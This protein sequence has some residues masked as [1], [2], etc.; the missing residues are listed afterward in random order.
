VVVRGAVVAIHAAVA[1]VAADDADVLPSLMVAPPPDADVARPTPTEVRRL[2]NVLL[3][4]VILDNLA[5]DR[6][7]FG[8]PRPFAHTPANRFQ[9]RE[10]FVR[11]R[12]QQ[13]L[14]ERGGHEV[15]QNLTPGR[16]EQDRRRTPSEPR[17]Q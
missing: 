5:E 8:A 15:V 3:S 2:L 1:R 7:P 16:D 9:R 6:L 4:L 11:G 12:V 10:Q 13:Q 14:V 17:T